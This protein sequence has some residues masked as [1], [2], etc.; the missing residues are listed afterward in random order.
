[1]SR[2]AIMTDSASDLP[3][4][5]A[6]R[7]GIVVVP[8]EVSFGEERFTAGVDLTTEDFWKRMTA[9]DAPFPKTAAASAG[10]FR[11]A[12]D[13]AFAAGADA[14]VCITV[15]GTLSGTLKSASIARDD[16][17]ADQPERKRAH[18]VPQSLARRRDAVSSPS[19]HK[20]ASSR[21]AG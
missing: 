21:P 1:M 5:T 13:E 20:S 19:P 3:A 9:P 16:L 12:Y 11:T 10:Q 14:V 17:K 6:A 2:V 18:M 15:A 7:A 8:L 4:S